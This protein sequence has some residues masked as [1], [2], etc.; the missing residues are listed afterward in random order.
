MPLRQLEPFNNVGA[1]QR[2]I[3]QSSLVLG[4]TLEH[5]EL[6][7]GGTTF[8]K[9]HVGP[10]RA[11]VNQKTIWE[12]A[13]GAD[14]DKIQLYNGHPSPA[15]FLD[16]LF[17]EPRARDR[18]GQ[19]AGAIDLSVGA[20]NFTLEMDILG[21]TAPTLAAQAIVSPPQ[22]KGADIENQFSPFLRGMLLTTIPISA[23][24]NEAMYQ[25]NVPRGAILKRLYIMHANLTTFRAKRDSVDIWGP[26][27]VAQ[28]AQLADVYGHDPQSGL[29][30]Y[31]PMVDDNLSSAIPSVRARDGRT[32]D[33]QFLFTTSAADTLRVYSDVLVPLSFI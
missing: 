27:T 17:S 29:Y 31:D 20:S 4:N 25:V 8:N 19:M 26:T 5:I 15:G 2:A 13:S 33:F 22:S 11:K 30:V 16:M 3:L 1:N 28:A 14:W 23:A 21:A 7:L 18:L 9:T 6:T 10:T 32:A 24:V 12:I